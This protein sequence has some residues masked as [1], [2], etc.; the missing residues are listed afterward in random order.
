MH[1]NQ[2]LT[3][4]VSVRFSPYWGR[5]KDDVFKTINTDFC[6]CASKWCAGYLKSSSRIPDLKLVTF[7]FIELSAFEVNLFNDS[8]S[9]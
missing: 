7:T 3:G 2:G 1:Q 8:N 4:L 6:I 9:K 5:C